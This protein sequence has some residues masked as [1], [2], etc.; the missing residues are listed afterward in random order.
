MSRSDL[1]LVQMGAH[2]ARHLDT[3]IPY[4]IRH[5]WQECW[6]AELAKLLRGEDAGLVA[7]NLLRLQRLAQELQ[8]IYV[9]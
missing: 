6:S 5:E 1:C 9:S 7:A 8:W 3:K 2:L 4:G